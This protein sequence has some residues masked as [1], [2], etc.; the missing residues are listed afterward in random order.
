MCLLFAL[1][2]LVG[3]I[4]LAVLETALAYQED[5]VISSQMDET[6]C[7]FICHPTHHPWVSSDTLKLTP[8]ILPSQEAVQV[9]IDLR[10]DPFPSSIF[11]PPLAL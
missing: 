11:H 7:C 6:H 9:K 1:A 5:K 3:I 10:I 8:R 2:A 4:N